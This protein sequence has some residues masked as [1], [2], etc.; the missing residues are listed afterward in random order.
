M[1]KNEKP[2]KQREE[3]LPFTEAAKLLGS[4][5]HT[6][7]ANLV[8]QGTL[9]AYSLPLTNKLRVRKSEVFKLAQPTH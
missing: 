4:G 7:I 5:N 3:F 9:P 6:R 1:K 8:K 2:T